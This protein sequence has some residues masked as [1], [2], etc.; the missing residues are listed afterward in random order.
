MKIPPHIISIGR[1]LFIPPLIGFLIVIFMLYSVLSSYLIKNLAYKHVE[2]EIKSFA[3]IVEKGLDFRNGQWDTTRYTSDPQ[4][5]HPSGSGGFSAPLYIVTTDGFVI[6]RNAPINGLLDSSDFNHLIKFQTPQTISLVTNDQWRI[7]SRPITH[8]NQTK[9]VMVVAFY[10]PLDGAEQV[11][12]EKLINN[13]DYLESRISFRDSEIDIKEINISEIDVDISF[14]IVSSF[15][16]VLLNNGRMPT[17]IDRSYVLRELEQADQ[18]RTV[19]D[20]QTNKPY[21]VYSH[22]I[23]DAENTPIGI[24]V[25]A[26]T[27]AFVDQL[28]NR[29]IPFVL[30]FTVLVVGLFGT[31]L[32]IVLNTY[33]PRILTSYDEIKSQATIPSRIQFDRTKS[34]LLFDGNIVDIP[35]A[36]NQYYLCEA[37]FSKPQK[38]W[39]HDEL[40]KRFGEEETASK[41]V[42]DAAL[43]VNKKVGFKLI[44]YKDK[45][46]RI[47]PDLVARIES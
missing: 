44:V 24:I 40:L 11:I 39:E 22:P 20:T 30:I 2:N 41:K 5:P 28:M 34:S 38:R 18:I 31:V 32:I 21:L 17:F 13:L 36:S 47:N 35:Y 19:V 37:L 9:G 4:T 10:N 23:R 14:E 27:T 12:D 16:K 43:A 42:Y 15:N 33:L 46:F 29:Y 6:E 26:E 3:T 7:V 1:R 45:T 25:I 8:N